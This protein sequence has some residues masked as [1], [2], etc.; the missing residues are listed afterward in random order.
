[1]TVR[2]GPED[3]AFGLGEVIRGYRLYMGLS[4]NAMAIALDVA[5]RS[6]ERIE[7]GDRAC[8]PGFLDSI[9]QIVSEFDAAVEYAVHSGPDMPVVHVG[10]NEEWD[11]VV[12]ARAAVSSARITPQ[13]VPAITRTVAS[14]I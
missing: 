6:Y 5:F 2:S 10:E 11:R 3:Y 9:R 4:R 8:P 12:A 13:L 1:M 7:D 14:R